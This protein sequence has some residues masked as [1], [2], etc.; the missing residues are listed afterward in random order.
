MFQSSFFVLTSAWY[1][2]TCNMVSVSAG[3]TVKE[4]SAYADPSHFLR[5]LCFEPQKDLPQ[6]RMSLV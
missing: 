1:P 5:W 2:A 3:V 4:G 6:G